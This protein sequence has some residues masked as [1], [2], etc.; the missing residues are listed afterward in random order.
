[1]MEI[2]RQMMGVI[3]QMASGSTP[4]INGKKF[5]CGTFSFESDTSDTLTINH[6]LGVYPEAIFVWS[7]NFPKNPDN[8]NFAMIG[9]MKFENEDGTSNAGYARTANNNYAFGATSTSV[10]WSATSTTISI[11]TNSTYMWRSGY[12]YQWLAIGGN[13]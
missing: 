3:A 10:A 11:K 6:N 5:D 12:T 8:K 9:G 2:R 13:V 7:Y 1:M 4:N